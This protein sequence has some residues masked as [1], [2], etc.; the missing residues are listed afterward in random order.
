MQFHTYTNDRLSM[1]LCIQTI[2]RLRAMFFERLP[3]LSAR[4]GRVQFIHQYTKQPPKMI[5]A[6]VTANAAD[7]MTSIDQHKQWCK[8]L[9]FNK[10]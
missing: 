8:A 7:L 9:H 4:S 3:S 5:L 1:R 6:G 2:G 10:A